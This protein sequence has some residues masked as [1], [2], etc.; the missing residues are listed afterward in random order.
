MFFIKKSYVKASCVHKIQIVLDTW[1]MFITLRIKKHTNIDLLVI[2]DTK[3]FP[4]EKNKKNIFQYSNSDKYYNVSG[5]CIKF[6]W[7]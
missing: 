1:E 7:S 2:C 6:F 4:I 3:E 5:R